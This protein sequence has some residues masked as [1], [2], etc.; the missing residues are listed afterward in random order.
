MVR[1]KMIYPVER[2]IRIAFV[3][4]ADSKPMDGSEILNMEWMS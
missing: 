4:R 2:G 3:G 1:I